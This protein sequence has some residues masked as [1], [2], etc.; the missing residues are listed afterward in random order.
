MIFQ[1]SQGWNQAHLSL[2][3]ISIKKIAKMGAKAQDKFT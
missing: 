3:L 1:G 2:E